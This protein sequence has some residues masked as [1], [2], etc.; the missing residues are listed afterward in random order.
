MESVRSLRYIGR[1]FQSNIDKKHKSINH[2]ATQSYDLRLKIVDGNGKINYIPAF[3][4]ASDFF[5]G[6]P[7]AIIQR[8]SIVTQS[9]KINK[10]ML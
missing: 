7:D 9:I 5:N 3:A 2:V 4:A 8:K 6:K 1:P 10:P